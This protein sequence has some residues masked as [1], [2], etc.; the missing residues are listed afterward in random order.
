M[1][2][3][4]KESVSSGAAAPDA[5][6]E[7][8]IIAFYRFTPLSEQVIQDLQQRVLAL[9]TSTGLRGLLVL[10]PEGCNATLAGSPSAISAAKEIF[11]SGPHFEGM[12]FKHS[13]AESNPF[14]RLRVDLRPEIVT[15][16]RPELGPEVW[17]GASKAT[18]LSPK[19]WHQRLSQAE[20]P[21]I[22]IDT[23][24]SYETALGMFRGA[25]D[26]G[27]SNFGQFRDFVA[28]GV[29]PKDQPVYMYCTGGIRCEKASLE[30]LRQGYREVYQLEGGIL[31]YLEEF[32]GGQ[33]EGECFVFD[34]RVAV[35]T[36][37]R[38]SRQY[39]LCPHCG[40]PAKD[41][42]E[43][44]GCGKKSRVC[45]ACSAQPALQSCSKNCAYHLKR[46]E[47]G[48]GSAS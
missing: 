14:R 48:S 23:R 16:G 27:L 25:R 36:S 44:R 18:Y 41:W 45:A 15:L 12:L 3:Q 37:L 11:S 7:Q 32:P 31:K 19:E 43:C 40:N 1:D 29:I 34:H 30:M 42:L 6:Q 47:T 17:Q 33:Y 38:P 20:Q 5:N 28:S 10:A 22:V 39:S 35:D 24:N 8:E 13:R 9:G 4:P 26:P 21:P 46:L 2:Q